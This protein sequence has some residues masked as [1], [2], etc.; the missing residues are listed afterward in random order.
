MGIPVL[1]VFILPGMWCTCD[2]SGYPPW[3]CQYQEDQ[4]SSTTTPR[5]TVPKQRVFSQFNYILTR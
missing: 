3:D 1:P 5:D 4:C 2:T